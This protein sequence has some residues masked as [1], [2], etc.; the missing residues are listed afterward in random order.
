M[1]SAGAEVWTNRPVSISS[2]HADPYGCDLWP[3]VILIV[4]RSACSFGED[5]GNLLCVDVAHPDRTVSF[6]PS[7]S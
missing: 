3:F 7:A 5:R 2:Q 6:L 1:G 4:R